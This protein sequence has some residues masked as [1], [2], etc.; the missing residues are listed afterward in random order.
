M[1]PPLYPLILTARKGNYR[2]FH[3][4]QQNKAFLSFKQKIL[5]RDQYTCRFCNFQSD[6]YQE[7]VNIDHNYSNNLAENVVTACA[8][9][10]QC[11]FLDAIGSDATMGGEV[12][13]LPEISQPDLNNF[14]RVLFCSMDKDTPYKNKLQAIYLSLKDRSKAVEDCFGPESQSPKVFG[15]GLIDSNLSTDELQHPLL[16]ELRLLPVKKNFKN[17]INY[18]KKIVFS[19]I[20]L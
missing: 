5:I 19:K 20:P 4:R 11:F 16:K 14:C 2:K 3:A 7:V 17:Q 6:K 13:H 15:Q 12:I 1:T 8:F 18:W 10:A 9:C